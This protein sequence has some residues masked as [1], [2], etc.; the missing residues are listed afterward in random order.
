M[1]LPLI[2]AG[3]ILRR[4]EPTSVAVWM[5]VRSQSSIEVDVY[6]GVVDAGASHDSLAAIQATP[7]GGGIAR[8]R[9]VGANLHVGLVVAQI[10]PP[11]LPGELHSYNVTITPDGGQPTDLRKEGLL[12]NVDRFRRALGYVEGQLPGFAT[13]PARTE[14]LVLM[15]GSCQK[16]HGLGA[17]MQ[18]Q[19]DAII[20]AVVSDPIARP[21]ALFLTGDQIYADDVATCLLP[22][23][24]SLGA[25]LLGAR[26]IVKGPG[27]ADGNP[28]GVEVFP[29]GRRARLVA[30]AGMTGQ[31]DEGRNHLISLG[32][33]CALYL[34]SFSPDC[35]RPLA[36]A[37][38]PADETDD[39]VDALTKDAADEE[40]T[41]P[42]APEVLAPTPAPGPLEDSLTDLFPGDPTHESRE[43]TKRKKKNLH[44]VLERFLADKK[45]I[46]GKTLDAK[47]HQRADTANFRRALANVPTY[48]QLDDHDCA[49]DW[50]ITG[51]WRDRVL[52]NVL[53]QTIIR[54]ALVAGT[55]FQAWGNDPAAWAAGDR[56][57]L[58]DT[59]E[60][61][62][63][64]GAAAGPDEAATVHINTLLGLN[65]GADP[66][67][68][69]S[70][71]LD[72]PTHRVVVLDT[73]TRREYRTPRSPPGLLSPASLDQQLP[74]GPLP[75]GLELLVLVSPAPVLGPPLITDFA[76]PLFISTVDFFAGIRL[77]EQ[78]REEEAQTGIPTGRVPGS[79]KWDLEQWHV[80][81]EAF[82][83]FLD[84]LSTY[85]RVLVLAGDVH[86]GAA[87][88][89]AYVRRDPFRVSR[90][91]HFTSSAM[92]NA[93]GLHVPELMSHSVWGRVLQQFGLRKRQ[94]GW[95]AAT[96]EVLADTPVGERL[97]LRGRL[98]RS[99]VLLPDEG[100]RKPHPLV[101]PPDWV[102][103]LEEVLDMRPADVRPEA[104]RPPELEEED[105][106]PLPIDP[107]P[108]APPAPPLDLLHPPAGDLGYARL[109]QVHQEALG[110]SVA[111]GLQFL[112]NVGRV[113]FR[114]LDDGELK[115][116]QEL[117]SLR[118]K[119]E[120]E[121]KP[122]GYITHT[123]SLAPTPPTIPAQIGAG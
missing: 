7:A 92:R 72:G 99:P 32:E 4:V 31:Q 97:S 91:V 54:N 18:A 6:R 59:I 117:V 94:L 71:Q 43:E 80:N 86:Y 17:P 2:L 95:D 73:R 9:R 34:M 62:Y 112:N 98:H 83:R 44:E 10:T 28:A 105:V 41:E 47:I 76:Q 68:D 58:L 79:Q 35:W 37:H 118:D 3:P 103:E 104:T 22:A 64:A 75:S 111:R 93:W 123:A 16:P 23:L 121:D 74:A 115:V 8:T 110:Q 114:R 88:T 12:E 15:H 39:L 51:E 38:V 119:S 57:D 33:F 102:W 53:G 19:F 113:T 96:P 108:P 89:L 20:E 49:D 90:I 5:A 25:E 30:L 60:L 40:S 65:P 61:L 85:S 45:A 14:D 11:L 67:F 50:F 82:E 70:Y 29:A 1:A 26:E 46:L 84:R 78:R 56:K 109:A 13:C 116:S 106:P 101:R 81:P 24:A 48:M 27:P 55:L 100:W 63:P 122:E 52:G 21:H 66:K 120:D 69:F 36:K 42:G 87:F 107:D 77:T